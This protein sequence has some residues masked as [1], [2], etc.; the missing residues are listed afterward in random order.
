VKE[1]NVRNLTKTFAAVSLM[2][3]IGA[4]ALGVGDIKLHSALNQNLDAEIALVLSDTEKLSDVRIKLAPPSKFEE[5]GVPWSHFLSQIK[6]TTIT[7]ANGA[8]VVKLSSAEVFN[9]PFL[10]FLLEVSWPKGDIY[11]EFTVLVDPPAVYQQKSIPVALKQPNAANQQQLSTETVRQQPID[12][13]KISQS[14]VS[15]YGPTGSND[16]LWKI[17]EKVNRNKDISVE[18]MMIALYEANPEAFYKQNVNALAAGATLKVPANDVVMKLSQRQAKNEFYKQVEAWRGKVTTASSNGGQQAAD[19]AEAKNQLQLKAPTT[20]EINDQMLVTPSANEGIQDTTE[21]TSESLGEENQD[22]K[23]RLGKLEQQLADMQKTL[24]VKDEQLATLQSEQLKSDAEPAQE[25]P[26]ITS[27]KVKKPEQTK[28]LEIPK[29]KPQSAVQPESDAGLYNIIMGTVGLAALGLLGWMWW[30]KRKVED[31]T[32]NESM[33]A[34][35]SHISLPETDKDLVVPAAEVSQDSSYDVGTVGESSFLSEFTPSDLDAFETDQAE[36]DPIAEADV[37]LAY[38][39]YQQAEE[40][41][42]Q[43]I[44]SQ[45]E[46]DECKLKLFEIFSANENQQAFETYAEELV[47][48]GKKSDAVFWMKVSEM[49]VELCPES[50]LFTPDA[51][52]VEDTTTVE[53]DIS[54]DEILEPD[55][56]AQES[57]VELEPEIDNEGLEFDVSSLSDAE[58]QPENDTLDSDTLNLSGET[59]SNEIDFDLGAPITLEEESNKK[60]TETSDEIETIDLSADALQ[61]ESQEDLADFNFDVKSE[62]KSTESPDLSAESPDLNIEKSD[63][64][65]LDS[66]VEEFNFEFDQK[67]TTTSAPVE[68]LVSDSDSPSVSDIT[69]MDELETKIDLA[70]A[71]IDMGDSDAAKTI[72]EEVLEKGSDT[73]KEEA[74][75]IMEQL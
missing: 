27:G 45:P 19:T 58:V 55:F 16:T 7:K 74:Q 50:K 70:K 61:E 75:A 44:E 59:E 39:R 43:A 47:S 26:V 9:E 33:F 40:L 69:D 21:S 4:H 12:A 32:N 49:G 20:A 72:A 15:E 66:E 5:A 11:R 73:Q 23:N 37:Y 57:K 38:G 54:E 63:S 1:S 65:S 14:V 41:M 36:I 25:K 48:D 8:V 67:K 52:S 30:R 56:S 10:D 62:K 17:A 53:A 34:E 13:T 31:E 60:D 71:Y 46:R 64:D 51:D 6:F 42:R 28:K 2:T 3:P 68:N 29:S 35:S 18:Q 22:L 24:A